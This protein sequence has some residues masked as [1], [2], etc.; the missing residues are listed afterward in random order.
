MAGAVL[1][2][3]GITDNN[4]QCVL[5]EDKGSGFI[6][7][8]SVNLTNPPGGGG[9]PRAVNTYTNTTTSTW[10]RRGGL[11]LFSVLCLGLGLN[12]LPAAERWETL[13]AIH[14]VENPHN[15]PKAGPCGELGAYQFRENTW[16]MHTQ[17]PFKQAVNRSQSDEVAVRHYEWIKRGLVRAGL[18][19]T[20]YNIA[21]AWN[22]GLSATI[23]GR[24]PAATRNYA[25]R[26]NNLAVQ[27]SQARMAQDCP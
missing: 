21:L 1:V 5:H 14:W 8:Y 23:R 12:S 19:V 22:G 27:M 10:H 9:S 13:Q 18:P 4:R 7:E 16:R 11:L 6:W 2:A 26:V 25:E 3:K 20:P 15:S 24:V 17:V